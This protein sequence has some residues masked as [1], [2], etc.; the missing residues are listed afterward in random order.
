MF[1]NVKIQQTEAAALGLGNVRNTLSTVRSDL[2]DIRHQLNGCDRAFSGIAN[3]LSIQANNMDTLISKLASMED[4]LEKAIGLYLRYEMMLAG[5]AVAS[6]QAVFYSVGGIANFPPSL[7]HWTENGF[8]TEDK[9]TVR[10]RSDTAMVE[11]IKKLLSTDKYSEKT[12]KKATLVE[13]KDILTDLH[14]ELETI[15]GVNTKFGVLSMWSAG[16]NLSEKLHSLFTW[17]GYSRDFK[18]MFINEDKLKTAGNYTTIME[19]MVHEMR[20]AYQH[21]VVDN[22]ELYQVDATTVD[23]W[24]DN[25]APGNYKTPD[26]DG[27]EAYEN[28]PV[29][30]DAREF[31]GEVIPWW[32]WL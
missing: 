20:H 30:V 13:R 23:E 21:A 8:W 17:G 19:T 31:A 5:G 9:Q 10:D 18:Q 2:D 6:G 29:E 16:D 28:Q 11:E 26:V 32:W 3:A 12:W 1:C 22:P 15:F 14:K 24:T 7:V 4:G 25:L 27:F